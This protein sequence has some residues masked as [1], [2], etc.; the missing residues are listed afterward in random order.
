M[1][2]RPS[3]NRDLAEI[4]RRVKPGGNVVDEFLTERREEAARE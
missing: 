3:I 4:Q 1:N 2:R